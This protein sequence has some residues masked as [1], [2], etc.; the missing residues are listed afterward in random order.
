MTNHY[1]ARP[2]GVACQS[3]CARP[4]PDGHACDGCRRAVER[5]GGLIAHGELGFEILVPTDRL[6]E[7]MATWADVVRVVR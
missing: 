4:E 1:H 3:V 7:R 5:A 6:A 2:L